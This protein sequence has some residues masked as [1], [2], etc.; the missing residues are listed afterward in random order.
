MQLNETVAC[1]KLHIGFGRHRNDNI[2]SSAAEDPPS[3]SGLN[4]NSHR[5]THLTQLIF[6]SGSVPQRSLDEHFI[7]KASIDFN[8]PINAVY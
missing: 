7:T 1:V 3:F 2:S 8:I 5:I 6:N 4:I